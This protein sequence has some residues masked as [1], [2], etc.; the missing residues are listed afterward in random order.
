M[1]MLTN[2]DKEIIKALNKFRVMDRDSIAELFF[3]DLKNPKLAANNVLLRLFRD[4]R[5]QRSIAFVPFVY[6]GPDVEMKKNSAKIGHFLGILDVYKEMQKIGD[7]GSFLV[8]PKYLKKGCAEPDIYL[9]HK[10]RPFFVEVQRSIYSE[11]QM[12]EKLDRYIDLYNSGIMAKPF[13]H[14]LILSETRYAID[15]SIQWPFKIFQAQSFSDFQEQ[16]KNGQ[17]KQEKASIK[18]N[19]KYVVNNQKGAI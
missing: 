2:R 7:L 15:S 18:S 8:E 14:I 11:K 1:G 13:P 4:G 5:I 6:F 17:Q 10:G 16:L 12:Q 19:V 3:S 9:Q